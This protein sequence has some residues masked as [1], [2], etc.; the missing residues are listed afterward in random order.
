M[1]EVFENKK[2]R[3]IAPDK[4]DA[5]VSRVLVREKE[6]SGN[7]VRGY[8]AFAGKVRG[9]VK[10]V[11]GVDDMYKVKQGDILIAPATMPDLLPAMGR[12]AA[13]VTDTGGVT[14]H[15]AIISREMKKPCIVGTRVGSKVFKDGDRVEVDAEKGMVRK[16]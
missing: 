2:S 7:E 13:F 11:H 1:L 14:S 8:V 15:A 9:E 10:I 5:Y 12:A 6:F 3:F 4:I 16:I